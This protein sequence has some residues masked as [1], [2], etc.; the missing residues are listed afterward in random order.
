M[1]EIIFYIVLAVPGVKQPTIYE[2]RVKSLEE[3]IGKVSDVVMRPP[4]AI[5]LGGVMQ[6]SCVIRYPQ[7]QKI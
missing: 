3:C 4:E 1:I 7:G 6:A 2:E 5:T